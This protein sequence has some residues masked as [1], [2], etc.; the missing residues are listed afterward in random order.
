ML[1]IDASWISLLVRPNVNRSPRQTAATREAPA[2]VWRRAGGLVGQILHRI[3]AVIDPGPFFTLFHLFHAFSQRRP[4]SMRAALVQLL[5]ISIVNFPLLKTSEE[6]YG[7]R[8]HP[9]QW[10]KTELILYADVAPL[11]VPK[12]QLRQG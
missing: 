4:A 3:A 7:L 9:R 6:L 5:G 8:Q 2:A 11:C 1:H 12:Q 10:D